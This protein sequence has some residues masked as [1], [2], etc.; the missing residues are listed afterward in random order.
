MGNWATTDDVDTYT[1]AVVEGADVTRAEFIVG[2]FADADPEDTTSTISA[3]NRRLL[4]AATAYQAAWMQQHPDVFSNLD[5]D[6][7]RQ[8]G[9]D[10]SHSHQNAGVLAPLAKRSID[11]LSWRRS[12]SLRTD[13]D[14]RRFPKDS[15]FYDIFDRGWRD[16]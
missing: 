12:R 10:V 8:D 5:A 6:S 7:V 11:R 16:L 4:R 9:V 15:V 14:L 2:L 3:K 13:Q 1:G